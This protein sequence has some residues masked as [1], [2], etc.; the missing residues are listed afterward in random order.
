MKALRQVAK[1]EQL[2]Q[3]KCNFFCF[4]NVSVSSSGTAKGIIIFV[5]GKNLN[6]K[7]CAHSG[8]MCDV[9]TV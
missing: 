7:K 3:R 6:K 4:S 5:P 8:V 1:A 2:L 9:C